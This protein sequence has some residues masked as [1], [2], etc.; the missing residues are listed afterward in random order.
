MSAQAWHDKHTKAPDT[1]DDAQLLRLIQEAAGLAACGA[2]D[3]AGL[4]RRFP[5]ANGQFAKDQ[6]VAA[7]RRFC[8]Q[9][10]LTFDRETLRRLQMKP[11]RTLSGVATV[12]VLTKPFPCPGE[13]SFC[14][15]DLRMPK[16]YLA[17]EPAA[18]RA[19]HHTFDH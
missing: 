19:E 14:P 2:G 7:Y 17:A 18:N 1:A 16:S 13:C 6:I 11:V 5:R 4:L 3:M 8:D 12:T 15:T 10:R 9:G